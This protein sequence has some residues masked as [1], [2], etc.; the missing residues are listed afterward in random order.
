MVLAPLGAIAFVRR[1]KLLFDQR[2]C[3]GNDHDGVQ[4]E[5]K[6]SGDKKR[7]INNDDE[8]L[9]R[10]LAQCLQVLHGFL[11]VS[12]KHL[13][14]RVLTVIVDLCLESHNS[15]VPLVEIIKSKIEMASANSPA[16]HARAMKLKPKPI[17]VN[18]TT[19]NYYSSNI[20]KP[21]TKLLP[22]NATRIATGANA[23]IFKLPPAP[24]LGFAIVVSLAAILVVY[25]TRIFFRQLEK[26]SETKKS[27]D[28]HSTA[29]IEVEADLDPGV[30][31]GLT[32]S[33]LHEHPAIDESPSESTA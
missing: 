9:S 2:N 20:P 27:S 3:Q 4:G 33:P 29:S 7:V 17:G 25:R 8:D 31:P 28:S 12:L 5:D 16:A 23:Q 11:M 32:T 22:H 26:G 10:L 6:G 13:C 14:D 21:I 19:S 18:N 30:S 15:Q 24:I 1:K